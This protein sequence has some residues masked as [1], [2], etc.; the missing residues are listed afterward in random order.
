M[1]ARHGIAWAD[2]SGIGKPPHHTGNHCA[3]FPQFTPGVH[4]NLQHCELQA[5]CRGH[6]YTRKAGSAWARSLPMGC[7]GNAH[8][9]AHAD[10]GP[11]QKDAGDACPWGRCGGALLLL[12][13]PCPPAGGG[14][15]Y[16]KSTGPCPPWLAGAAYVPV[17]RATCPVCA[18]LGPPA[19]IQ[20][21]CSRRRTV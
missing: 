3:L 12:T 14:A 7:D 2:S 5:Y 21:S 15:T 19:R 10:L 1:Q 8:V 16:L 4:A 20:A 6:C 18:G 13:G 17:V 11:T 9:K